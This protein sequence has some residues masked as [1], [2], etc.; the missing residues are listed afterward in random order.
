[1]CKDCE[2]PPTNDP[3][4]WGD[5][6][7]FFTHGYVHEDE[8][9]LDSYCPHYD[10]YED[11]DCVDSDE[12]SPIALVHGLRISASFTADPAANGDDEISSNIYTCYACLAKYVRWALKTF[13]V[14]G[15]Y[16][17]YND[18][19]QWCETPAEYDAF[20]EHVRVR[21]LTS[22]HWGLAY[23]MDYRD[24]VGAYA[25]PRGRDL[26]LTRRR[27][28]VDF[29][30]DLDICLERTVARAAL[31]PWTR[32]NHL[33]NLVFTFVYGERAEKMPY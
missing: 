12:W 11:Q 23:I 9:N 1:M 27:S 21:S 8:H 10:L 24:M 30:V 7:A 13:D 16:V 4:W 25:L 33:V 28:E 14:G 3:F 5:C 18:Q 32:D 2:L 17:Y 15:E 29:L 22:F 26:L 6:F 19:W 20:L 31:L